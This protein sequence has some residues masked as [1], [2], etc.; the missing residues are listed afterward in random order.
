MVPLEYCG[1]LLVYVLFDDDSG[2][3]R[4]CEYR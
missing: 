1:F 2:F 3:L 4:V